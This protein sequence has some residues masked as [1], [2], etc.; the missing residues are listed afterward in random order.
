MK[1]KTDFSK[2]IRHLSRQALES[3]DSSTI[4]YKTLR[5]AL[6]RPVDYMRYAEFS[7]ILD[8]LELKPNTVVLDV[9]SPQW[10]CIYLA[11][12]YPKTDFVYIN[13]IDSEIEPF[14]QI[15]E[16][17]GI[18]NLKYLKEDVRELSFDS[19]IFD[20][21][22]SISVIEH[23]YPASGGDSVALKEINRVLK[24]EGKLHLTIPYKNEGNV[25]Y[26]DGDV[27]E[28]KGEAST[29]FAREYDALSFSVL[30]KE[31]GFSADSLNYIIEK[32]GLLSLDYYEW[33]PGKSLHLVKYLP[34]LLKITEKIF[35]YSF[36]EA[37]AQ[38][39]LH[40]V[41]EPGDRLV[42]LA[43]SLKPSK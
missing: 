42:N 25:V 6:A 36:E 11:S 35:H 29:F 9:S 43:A 38:K 8:Q 16:T 37:L 3:L 2:D 12:Q 20:Q 17:L 4:A 1:L 19:N 13:I 32:P 41:A 21:V 5:K 30:V 27:Y 26:V 34:K 39:N 31:S 33:G 28:R 7:A 10:F 14:Q 18:Q 23:I 24:P 22:I 40:V 15:R